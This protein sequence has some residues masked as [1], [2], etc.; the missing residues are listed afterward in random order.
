MFGKYL[1]R[2]NLVSDGEPIATHSSDLLPVRFGDVPAMLKVARSEEE[3]RGASLMAWW[4]GS[5]AARVLAHDGDAILMERATSRRSL[6]DMAHQG[7]DD[8]ASRIICNVATTLHARRGPPPRDLV[9]LSDW[10]AELSHVAG[11]DTGIF[12][13]AAATAGELLAS[14]QEQ[15]VLHGDLHHRNVLDFGGRGWLAIDPKGLIGDHG[16]DF[17]NILCNPDFEIATGPGRMNRQIDV[18]AEAAQLDPARL[19]RWV[20]AY[21]ALSAAW[22]IGEGGDPTLAFTIAHMAAAEIAAG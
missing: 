3:R 2:W 12:S 8:E 4:D 18:V 19:L 13:Q 5:G 7:H 14:T 10:Y 15:H 9:P 22:T 17:A 1:R 21:A 16:F 20:F 11:T 6:A